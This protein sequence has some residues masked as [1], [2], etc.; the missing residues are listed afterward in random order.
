M[1]S[2][3]SRAELIA[4]LKSLAALKPDDAA[5]GGRALLVGAMRAADHLVRLQRR[6]SVL[7][8]ASSAT[9]ACSMRPCA[10]PLTRFANPTRSLHSSSMH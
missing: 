4:D 8:A 6:P 9:S 3:L 10:T 2:L 1:T 7:R 5:K